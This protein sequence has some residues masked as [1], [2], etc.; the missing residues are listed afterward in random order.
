TQDQISAIITDSVTGATSKTV[1]N[2]ERT[3]TSQIVASSTVFK[4]GSDWEYTM[5]LPAP[6]PSA[7]ASPA[8]YDLFTTTVSKTQDPHAAVPLFA[9][10][11]SSPLPSPDPFAFNIV[12]KAT[13]AVSGVVFDACTG[14]PLTGATIEL[15]APAS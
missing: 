6:A 9:G 14:L 3:G 7:G 11:Y 2:A 4:V 5:I 13:K 8:L 12:H 15:F 10:I 1:V